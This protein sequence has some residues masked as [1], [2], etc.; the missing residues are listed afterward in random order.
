MIDCLW[1]CYYKFM[2]K[3]IELLAVGS[4]YVDINCTHFPFDDQGFL[5][6]TEVVGEDYE[7][8]PGGSAL[9]FVR[10][11]ANLGCSAAFVGKVGQDRMGKLLTELVQGVWDKT[12][13]YKR[14]RDND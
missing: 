4:A 10:F 1:L 7:V 12:R 13:V 8:V 6:E 14:Y 2:T 11:C 3:M 9:N 5:P